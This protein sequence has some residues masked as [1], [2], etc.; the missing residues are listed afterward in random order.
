[1][2]D[3]DR[4]PLPAGAPARSAHPRRASAEGFRDRSRH[5]PSPTTGRPRPRPPS[6]CARIRRIGR[7]RA[8]CWRTAVSTAPSWS[9]STR[10]GGPACAS[11]T[12][13]T[14]A[15]RSPGPRSRPPTGSAT[16]RPATSAPTPCAQ[17]MFAPALALG[18]TSVRNP[19]PAAG[20]VEPESLEE[21][22]QY[23]PQAFRRQERA[24]TDGGLRR[25]RPAPSGGA[26]GGGDAPLDRQLVHRLRHRR[27]AGRRPVDAAFEA[28]LRELLE[29]FRMAGYDLEVGRPAASSR[30][31]SRSTSASSR[32]T[33]AA[34]CWRP[35]LE[36]FG[37]RALPDGRRGFF[38][39]DQLHLRPAGLPLAAIYAAAAEVEGVESVTRE[40]LP[41]LG[42]AGGDRDPGRRAPDRPPGDRPARQR[43]ELPGER[44]GSR[45][46]W[47]VASERRETIP[48]PAPAAAATGSAGRAPVHLA[49]RPGLSALAY[50]VGTHARFKA[51]D[52][53]RRSPTKPALARRSPPAT[54]TIRRSRCSTPGRSSPTC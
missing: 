44:H 50:R 3:R 23:A 16:A 28:R 11:A 42:P 2:P 8:T 48:S 1:M 30:S 47:E 43:S 32:T 4:G 22:R 19:L 51:G 10:T 29:R 53:A 14:A 15:P 34:R 54:T 12:T 6:A 40:A 27:P 7:R 21:V 36:R 13:R 9:R 17:V 45:F 37:T 41:A 18:I 46:P 39:P 49:N 33:S 38:H 20:G 5:A 24:V 25:R 52:A 31:T 26:A 35:L